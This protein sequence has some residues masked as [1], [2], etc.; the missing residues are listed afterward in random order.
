ML[1]NHA[2][3]D[4]PLMSLHRSRR[5]MSSDPVAVLLLLGN[6]FQLVAGGFVIS[7]KNNSRAICFDMIDLDSS[8]NRSDKHPRLILSGNRCAPL[9]VGGSDL[10]L[11][12]PKA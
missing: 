5:S 12:L 4:N 6:L 3:H 8:L 1:D 9:A 2:A 10:S 7:Y 11:N